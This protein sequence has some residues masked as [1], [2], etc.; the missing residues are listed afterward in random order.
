MRDEEEEQV[1]RTCPE[2]LDA[3]FVMT[4]RGD[5]D[6]FD[7]E[8]LGSAPAYGGFASDSGHGGY[9]KRWWETCVIDGKIYLAVGHVL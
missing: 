6:L 7:S 8:R 9:V 3:D 1:R 2:D 4:G 5:V